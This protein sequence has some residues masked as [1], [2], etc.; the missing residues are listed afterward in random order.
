[1]IPW[2]NCMSNLQSGLLSREQPRTLAMGPEMCI[3]LVKVF[4]VSTE[5]D[6]LPYLDSSNNGERS[7]LCP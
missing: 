6:C 2:L 5:T 1:M 4:E 3:G 7:L